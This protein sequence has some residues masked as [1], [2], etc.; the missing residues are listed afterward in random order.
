MMLGC[1]DVVW[2]LLGAL[3]LVD[4]LRIRGRLQR[5]VSWTLVDTSNDDAYRC[6][7]APDVTVSQTVV[8][9]MV[10]HMETKGVSFVE[11][12]P[13]KVP[14]SLAWSVG[15]HVDAAAEDESTDSAA[16]AFIGPRAVLDPLLAQGDPKDLA[17]FFQASR[18]ARRRVNGKSRFV[19]CPELNASTTN[20]FFHPG[21]LRVRLGGST[22]PV[23]LG[24][25]MV[26][27]LIVLGLFLAPLGG[28][29][30]LFCFLAQQLIG[31]IGTGFRVRVSWIQALLRP[32]S[33]GR[34]WVS[35]LGLSGAYV[36]EIDRYRSEYT[37]RLAQGTDRFFHPPFS[38][39]PMCGVSELKTRFHL[40]DL[41][42]NKPGR[43]SISRCTS[44]GHH[45]QNPQ[46]N[47]EGL[48]FYYA[49]FYDG[50][51]ENTMDMVFGATGQLYDDRIALVQAHCT[52][53]RWLDVGCG[54][55]HLF[56]HVRATCPNTRLEG[57]DVGAGIQA[58]HARGWMD[59]CHMGYFPECA[60]ALQ[61]RFDVVSMCHYLE[62]TVDPKQEI[63]AAA[64]VLRPNGVLLIEVPDP[65][66]P[67]ARWL[68]RW[69][70]PWFQPQHLHFLSAETLGKVLDAHGFTVE[71]WEFGAAHTANEFSLSFY[72]MVCFWA[73]K[74]QVP[75]RPKPSWIQ[76]IS[77]VLVWIP[78]IAFVAV[79]ALLDWSTAWWM[80]RQKHVGQLRVLAR[81]RS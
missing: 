80:R 2:L 35:L 62:H 61:D 4:G 3:F 49:D 8:A 14:L 60:V 64:L 31:V 63:A 51:G 25:P 23:A 54:H 15:C 45:F 36:A 5:I 16:H 28:C 17:H 1:L 13:C 76:R 34:N 41:Y 55:G 57:L 58:G 9:Q 10:A 79:G 56:S 47:A 11:L 44:C 21:L 70:M 68:G 38:E 32:F 81:K 59:D 66:A 52:P 69:W 75:W 37:A 73:P 40:P 26:W 77:H 12:V 46:L 22:T 7:V 19:F 20:P 39:C 33:D 71:Q 42:Q 67:L 65:Q 48:S 29:F 30:A 78:G 18:E 74:L 72:G 27:T 43:F 24:I 53:T 6:V 50:I